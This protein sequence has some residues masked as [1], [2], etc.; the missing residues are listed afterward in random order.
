MGGIGVLKNPHGRYCRAEHGLP[1]S[2]L[3]IPPLYFRGFS[4]GSP[5]GGM[6]PYPQEGYGAFT[7]FSPPITPWGG[8]PPHKRNRAIFNGP[9][10]PNPRRIA[11]EELWVLWTDLG[12]IGPRSGPM[13]P[14][15]DTPH[16]R[17]RPLF[18]PPLRGNKG[19]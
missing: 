1:P 9:I 4:F 8:I 14:W 13:T 6:G 3:T 11:L 5:H 2:L 19:P 12:G 18:P 16:G 15:G 7:F 10:T 17:N